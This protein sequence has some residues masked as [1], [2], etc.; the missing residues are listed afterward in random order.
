MLK[1]DITKNFKIDDDFEQWLCSQVLDLDCSLS[2]LIR[3]SILL[4]V[5]LIRA[6]PALLRMVTLE[7]F[8]GQ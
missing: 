8:K 1:K 3:I 6:N 2:E 5:P 4:A 7:Q